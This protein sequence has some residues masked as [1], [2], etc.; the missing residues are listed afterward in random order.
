MN[1]QFEPSPEGETK[2]KRRDEGGKG[3]MEPRAGG[4]KNELKISGL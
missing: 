3:R 4:R 1:L 2:E